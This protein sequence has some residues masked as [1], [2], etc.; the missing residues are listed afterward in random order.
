LQQ[1][2]AFIVYVD[3]MADNKTIND[4]VLRQLLE[5]RDI[6]PDITTDMVEYVSNNLLATNQIKKE[7]DYA[8]IIPLVLSGLTALFMEGCTQCILVESR[9]YEKRSVSTPLNENVIKGS[10]EAFVENLRTNI[11]LVRRIIR[12]QNL[13]TEMLPVGKTNHNTCGLLYMKEIANPK[14]IDEVKRRI[15]SIDIDYIPSSGTLDQLIEDHPHALFPQILSTERPDRTASFLMEGKVALI[16]DGTPFASIVPV[17][18]FH[19]FHTSEDY[20]LRWQTGTFLRLIRIIAFHMAIYLPGLYLALSLY[21]QEMI[22]SELLVSLTRSKENIPFPALINMLLVETSWEL[23]RE[24]GVRVPGA[25]G[26]TLGIIGGVI[27]GQAAVSAGLVDPILII[28]VAIT[29]LGNFAIPNFGLSFGIR[30]LR[31]LFILL[32]AF[33]GFYSIAAGIFILGGL[34]CSMKS[35]GVPYFSPIAPKAKAS[36]DFMIRKPTWMQRIRADAANP[37]ERKRAGKVIRGWKQS[38]KGDSKK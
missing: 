20:S 25:I 23:I 16:C 9:G 26:Q 1:C 3:G 21:H 37:I 5:R 4:Y 35:F 17:T 27:L 2:N 33:G 15:N 11:T 32:A 22:P 12:N 14:I 24:A 6:I 36:A 31:F 34:A 29:G 7:T 38:Q 10:Q 30:L 28:I 18:F 19:M 13:V 8:K